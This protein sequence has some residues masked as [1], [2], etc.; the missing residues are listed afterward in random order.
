MSLEL[1][2]DYLVRIVEQYR[3]IAPQLPADEDVID[4][5]SA[6]GFNLLG[7][8]VV[9]PMGNIVEML[10][11]PESTILPGVQPWILGLANVRGRLLPLFDL[12]GF[13][14]GE[15]TPNKKRHRV[16]V[17]EIGDLFA[18]LI[19]N[20]VYGMQAITEDMQMSEVSE[21]LSD[22]KPYSAGAF[23]REDNTWVVFEPTK[24][25][26]DPRFFNASAQ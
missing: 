13:F 5:W 26:R 16:L 7:H 22:L 15:L 4:S 24:L 23:D 18:G 21:K 12:E 3:Q 14:G 9:A 8:K 20:E 11:V 19:V 17:I 6:I 10:P 1:P 25:V 2:F